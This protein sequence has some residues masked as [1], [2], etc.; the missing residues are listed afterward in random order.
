[1]GARGLRS[2]AATHPG[3]RSYNEDAYADR[4]DLGLWAVADGDATPV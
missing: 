2:S 1:M 4:P 3:K